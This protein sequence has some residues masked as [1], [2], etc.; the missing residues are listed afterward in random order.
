MNSIQE[1]A[2]KKKI[3]IVYGANCTNKKLIHYYY[4][5]VLHVVS[6]KRTTKIP[7]LKMDNN[8]LYI[9]CSSEEQK[10]Q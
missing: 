4:H 2:I 1:I 7:I 9:N 5:D 6:N 10:I 8:N 3:S